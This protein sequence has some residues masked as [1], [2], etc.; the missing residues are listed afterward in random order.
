MTSGLFRGRRLR[1]GTAMNEVASN[2]SQARFG[3]SGQRWWA[4]GVVALAVALQLVVLVPFTV[5]SGLLAPLWAVLLLYG[6]WL[7]GALLLVK[8]ARPRPFATPI[9]P[10]VN[11]LLLWAVISGGE[12]WLGWT[13]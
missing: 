4:F 2:R 12:I 6:L 10:A 5:A 13:A 3:G 9:V 1:K 7:A 8:L 11:A